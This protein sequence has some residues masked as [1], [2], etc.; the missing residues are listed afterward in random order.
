L[1]KNGTETQK[2]SL[3]LKEIFE[4]SFDVKL[5]GVFCNKHGLQQNFAS[6]SFPIIAIKDIRTSDFNRRLIDTNFTSHISINPDL[7]DSRDVRPWFEK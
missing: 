2:K 1:R 4:C 5:W 7:K 3:E 6:K